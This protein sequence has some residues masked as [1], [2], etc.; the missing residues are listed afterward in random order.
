[1]DDGWLLGALLSGLSDK[2]ERTMESMEE[3]DD[4]T[5]RKALAMLRAADA[6]A[7]RRVLR[8]NAEKSGGAALVAD[9]EEDRRARR[10][11]HRPMRCHKCRKVGHVQRFCPTR[12][13]KGKAKATGPP[14]GP[15]PGYSSSS[16][17]GEEEV[18]TAGLAKLSL[19][20]ESDEEGYAM[21]ARLLPLPD[22]AASDG[23]VA[24]A[25]DSGASHHMCGTP[26]GLTDVHPGRPVTIT[27]ANGSTTRATTRGTAVLR[28]NGTRLTLR[29]VLVVPS[30]AM[31]L[32][33]VRTASRAGYTT[34]FSDSGV[35]VHQDGKTI[36]RG[37][38]S[39]GIYVLRGHPITTRRG[40][41]LAAVG[42][43]EDPAEA[44]TGDES[45]G[46]Q[47]ATPAPAL[48]A[49]PVTAA[50]TGRTQP[51][52][53][54]PTA[55]L[56]HRRYGHMS[57]D[58]LRRTLAAVDG[59]DLTRSSLAT[60]KGHP[61][62]PC[63]MSKMARAPYVAS[64]REPERVLQYVNS[65]VIGPM[66]V[67]TAKGRRYLMG[68]VDDYSRYKEIVPIHEKG[69]A[70]D[71][72]MRVLNHWENVTGHRI[73]TLR[74]DD[75][76]EY[77]GHAFDAWLG[78]KGIKH[79]TSAPYAHQHNG[80]AERFNRTVQE[81]MM[82]VLT[83]ARLE[84]K[85]WGEAATAV[86]R[87]LNRTPQLGHALTPYEMFY[88][89]RPDVSSMRVFRCRAWAYKP[90]DIRRKMDPRALPATHMGYADTSKGY[91]VLINGRVYIRR[92]V[93]FDEQPVGRGSGGMPQC[94]WTPRRWR[95]NPRERRVLQL[96]RP[97]RPPAGSLVRLA[98][99]KPT[100]ETIA[101]TT[102]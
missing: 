44:E 15:P 72:L 32:F 78:E 24:W 38:T 81:R 53:V 49:P 5:I 33:S 56:W 58:G 74:T 80:V 23:E 70:K 77:R 42:G 95:Q 8:K 3:R 73:G 40:Q 59:M 4:I 84:H 34:E 75:G 67:P 29:D 82:A 96:R 50:V 19:E 30:M 64:D 26:D 54:D 79:E 39:G 102:A 63:I 20:S 48:T 1:M 90:P 22:E 28:V 27:I 21:L 12:Q 100:T 93:T 41:A 10:E 25:V 51:A 35:R 65:Y 85:F 43:P 62:E 45:E 69:Q 61:C 14:K 86:T 68:A 18:G 37:T 60:L 55:A 83:D 13:G 99:T 94:P 52:G 47:G 91:R 2:Y 36:V 6:R 9:G 98:R 11:A 7:E 71:A 17:S 101:R 92:D 87:A 57:V 16:S 46:H 76:K 97:S 88:G 66:P 31:T 89:R